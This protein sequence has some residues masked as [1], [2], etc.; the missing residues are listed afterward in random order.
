MAKPRCDLANCKSPAHMAGDCGF[1]NKH[2]CGKHRLL[3]DHKCEGLEDCK[4]EAHAQNAA[5]L[6]SERTQVIRGV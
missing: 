4:K 3:E 1:C 5:Q 2:F 6:E